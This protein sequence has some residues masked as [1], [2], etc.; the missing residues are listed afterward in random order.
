MIGGEL[1]LEVTDIPV[2]S[3]QF[4]WLAFVAREYT[5]EIK[6]SPPSSSAIRLSSMRGA[7]QAEPDAV[8]LDWL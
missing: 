5:A 1:A 4:C 6:G 2:D 7:W 8:A 3:S